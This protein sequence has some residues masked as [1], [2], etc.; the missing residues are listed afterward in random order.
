MALNNEDREEIITDY[1]SGAR[2]VWELANIHGVTRRRIEQIVT[3]AGYELRKQPRKGS[4]QISD[5]HRRIGKRLIDHRYEH[6][7]DAI[8]IANALG[9]T[10]VK[11]SRVE[12]GREV[13]ELLDLQKIARYLRVSFA[14]LVEEDR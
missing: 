5:L 13:L 4:V 10:V 1:T 9:M 7:L 14:A 3:A 2:H 6:S 12:G 11:Y 8:D